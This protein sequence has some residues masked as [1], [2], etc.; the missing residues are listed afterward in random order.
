M[1]SILSKNSTS[2]AV[3][4]Y[5]H[6]RLLVTYFLVNSTINLWISVWNS[7]QRTQPYLFRSWSTEAKRSPRKT[8]DP[9]SKS[10]TRRAAYHILCSQLESGHSF[11][12][13][14]S[15][16]VRMCSFSSLTYLMA[17]DIYP[18]KHDLKVALR[19]SKCTHNP[20]CFSNIFMYAFK[21]LLKP[22]LL[23]FHHQRLRPSGIIVRGQFLHFSDDL[24]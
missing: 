15:F 19:L 18:S 17:L 11:Y 12:I 22:C 5:S 13:L 16:R 1:W 10:L 8:L 24:V 3:K 9:C 23:H 6:N 4:T 14:T 21:Y 2:D 20:P 7:C